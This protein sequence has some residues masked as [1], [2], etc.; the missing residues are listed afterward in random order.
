MKLLIASKNLKKLKELEEIFAGALD[1]KIKNE[2]ELVSLADFPA[3]QEIDED[4]K[5]FEENA[6]KKA[7]GYAIATN[8]LTLADDSGL[9]VDALNGAPGVFSARFAGEGKDDLENCK[10]VLHSMKKVP[11]SKR[12]A[13]FE[14]VIAIAEPGRLIGTAKGEIKGMILAEMRGSG[15]FGYDPLFYYPPF[16]K[17]LA[18]IGQNLKNSVSHRSS[19]LKKSQ[20]IISQY[21]T[22][23]FK[24]TR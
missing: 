14:C 11:E 19:A 4:G 8:L 24:S 13:K 3:V 12:W 5:T 22:R 21:I 1:P 17:T 15:G 2:I 20:V 7:L 6:I 16:Q 23:K 9:S 10:K 18:E